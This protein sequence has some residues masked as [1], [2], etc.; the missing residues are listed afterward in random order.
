MIFMLCGCNTEI[1][2]DYKD[3]IENNDCRDLGGYTPPITCELNRLNNTLGEIK[4][5]LKAQMGK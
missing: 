1:K 3:K 2:E 4:D 5:L